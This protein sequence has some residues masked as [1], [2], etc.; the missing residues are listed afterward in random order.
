MRCSACGAAI[1]GRF[2]FC[3][4]CGH[5][6]STADLATTGAPAPPSGAAAL[7]GERRQVTVLFCDLVGSTAIAERLDPEEYHDLLQKYLTVAFPAIYRFEGVVNALAGD[8]LMALF[9]AP[10]AHEDDPQRA[11][12]A[13]L[14]VREAVRGLAERVAAD[15]GPALTVRI[16]VHTGPVVVGGF[17]TDLK[18]DYTAIGDTPNVAARLQTLAAPGSILISE[19]THR[20]VQ[21]FFEVH[22]A[23]EL[24]MKGKSDP[25]R[26]YEVLRRQM[27]ATAM[28][29]AAERGLTPFVGRAAELRRLEEAYAGLSRG[30]AQVVTVVG[31]AGMGKSRLVYEFRQRLAEEPVVFFESYCSSISQAIPYHSTLSMLR[32]FF[33]IEVGEPHE[34]A[35]GKIAERLGAPMERLEQAY[36]L[37]TRLLSR[38]YA[39]R[40]DAPA[41]ELRRET[42]DAI[43]R[44][45]VGVSQDAPVVVL[46]ED[47]H[48]SDEA[49]RELLA[50]LVAT[51]ERSRV[52]VLVTTRSEGRPA[53]RTRAARTEIELIPLADDEVRSM[54]R[55]LV[56]GALPRE[57]ED[58]LVTRAVGSPFFAEEFTRALLEAGELVCENGTCR[59]VRAPVDIPIPNTVQEVIAARLDRLPPPAKRALQLAAVLGRQFRAPD[60]AALAADGAL[61]VEAA[62]AEL[63]HRG[64]VHRKHTGGEDE[65]RFGESVTQEVAYEGLLLRQR[66]VLHDRAAALLEGRLDGGGVQRSAVIAYHRARGDDR[67]AA[68]EALLAAGRDAEAVPSYLTAAQFFSEAATLA[69]RAVAEHES[70]FERAALEALFGVARLVVL[71]GLPMVREGAEAAERGRA[72]A[73]R[74]GAIEETSSFLYFQGILTM[75]MPGGDFARGIAL[76]EEAS[77]RATAAG[78]E[79]QVR[80]I[81]RGLALNYALDGQM[82]KARVLIAPI[83]AELEPRGDGGLPSDGY[84]TARWVWAF[85]QF[86]GDELDAAVTHAAE[87]LVQAQRVNNRTIQSVVGT[88]L[89]QIALMRGENEAALRY[90]DQAVELAETIGNANVLPAAASVALLARVSL[91]QPV[92]VEEHLDRIDRGLDPHGLVQMNFRFVNEAWLLTGNLERVVERLEI[93]RRTGGA[94]LRRAVLELTR[95]DVLGRLGR[96]DEACAAHGEALRMALELQMRSLLVEIVVGAARLGEPGMR[97]VRRHLPAALSACRDLRLGRYRA[98]VEQLLLSGLGDPMTPQRESRV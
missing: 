91:G 36:P 12:R 58:R 45:L 53:W 59:L 89:G 17:G 7:E 43:A 1:E 18:R 25:V 74:L 24:T 35:S 80:R 85:V 79:L 40:R 60:V 82:E 22:S 64:L 78:S 57:I 32:R 38:P 93:M 15:G 98:T 84:L 11:V 14:A 69:E 4:E 27:A 28:S 48:W 2:R 30:Q 23:G 97:L 44:L 76:A 86:V 63:E 26:A 62:L 73:E 19:A 20:L 77:D 55:A 75:S 87:T 16:G 39:E 46:I 72:L 71:F 68:V 70:G 66:R 61:D 67:R 47:I 3:P 21:G 13:A 10:V 88:M 65:L 52:M 9:G 8:G 5:R 37:L 83:A 96:I 94:R 6:V 81:K 54:A 95:G 31:D 29:I 90:A 92:E 56:G 34:Q 49:S 33:G 50:T 41:D 42:F 51:L